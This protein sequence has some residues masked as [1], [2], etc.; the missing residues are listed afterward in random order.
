MKSPA[1]PLERVL[2]QSIVAVIRAEKGELLVDVAE[3]L[4]AGGVEVMEVT[5]TVPRA[6]KVL[7][8]VADA[9]GDRILLG[10]GTV[11]D[12]ETCRIALL[13]GALV[14]IPL[15]LWLERRR[16][17]AEGAIRVLGT[18]QTIPSLALLA[19]MVPFL[20][21]GA[22]PAVVA[23]WAVIG[24]GRW[25]LR[26]V[27]GAGCCGLWLYAV[28]AEIMPWGVSASFL[29][30]LVLC[31]ALAA[32][33]CWATGLSVRQSA[34]PAVLSG[35]R[36]FSLMNMLAATTAIA[37]LL[38]LLEALRPALE[39]AARGDVWMRHWD[40]TVRGKGKVTGR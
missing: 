29:A 27:G 2:D 24:P 38:G 3:S 17:W 28:R 19:F 22:L 13:A 8:K 25:W 32:A 34:A 14:A 21:I 5:F 9:I 20:G 37:G 16:R 10:A 23:L 35:R 6:A 33:L 4:L 7:E 36:Q 12:A 26:L 11:L 31:A 18:T 30:A 1:S 40:E 39:L 15:G